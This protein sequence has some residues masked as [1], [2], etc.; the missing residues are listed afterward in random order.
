MGRKAVVMRC[1]ARPEVRLGLGGRSAAIDARV[2]DRRRR[3]LRRF[4]GFRPFDD[5]AARTRTEQECLG[6]AILFVMITVHT[7]L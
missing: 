5:A 4:F 3:G 2:S 7:H 6:F 1:W